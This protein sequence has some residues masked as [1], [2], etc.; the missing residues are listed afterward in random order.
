[1]ARTLEFDY[2]G[3]LERAT[4][5]FW[6]TGYAGTPL[7]D[8]LKQMRIGEGS[9]YNTLKSKKNAFLEC[10]KHYNATVNRQRG[11]VLLG[12]PT[13]AIGV[14]ALF[15]IVLDCLDDPK[16]PSRIC[17][18]AG[19]I[20]HE[21]LADPDLRE[22]VQQQMSM[23]TERMAMRM[24]ADKEAGFLPN[25]LEP[26]IVA[27]VIV[28]YLQGLWRMALVSYDRPQYEKQIETLL[29]GLGL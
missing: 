25:A 3:A 26:Q 18:M 28:A 10:L 17:L 19:S 23:F 27:Q 12:A 11:E 24:A 1:L 7:R 13:A 9:F 22:Y 4:H 6:E 2:E 5:V 15:N 14:R 29:T 8:L 16:T 20:T 21:V